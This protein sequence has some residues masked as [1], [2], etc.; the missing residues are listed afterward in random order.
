MIHPI[1]KISDYVLGL[2][3][4]ATTLHINAHLAG[5]EDCLQRVQMER[6]I[7]S[8]VRSTVSAINPSQHELMALL[9]P[10]PSKNKKKPLARALQP[11]FRVALAS[12]ALILVLFVGSVSFSQFSGVVEASPSAPAAAPALALTETPTLT[13]TATTVADAPLPIATP[14]IEETVTMHSR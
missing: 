3:D 6:E 4:N 8:L 10:I 14:E 11:Q 9:P 1:D 7:G 13:A 2:A 5:C 12:F